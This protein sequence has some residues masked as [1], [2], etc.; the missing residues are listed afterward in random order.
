MQG[1]KSRAVGIGLAAAALGGLAVGSA[2]GQR[3]GGG[4]ERWRKR[5]RMG[6]HQH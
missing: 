6:V 2:S 4:A 5:G 1:L 3:L